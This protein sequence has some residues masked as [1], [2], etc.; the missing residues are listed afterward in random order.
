M[1]R[2]V[3]SSLRILWIAVLLLFGAGCAALVRAALGLTPSIP[4]EEQVKYMVEARRVETL[5]A[6]LQLSLTDQQ[7]DI[8]RNREKASQSV[9]AHKMELQ[10]KYCKSFELAFPS[11]D[12]GPPFCK[13]KTKETS[14]K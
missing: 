1:A 3:S 11:D 13:P 4:L 6:M 12:P 10:S 2:M 8:I 14:K 9:A 5:D 7:R